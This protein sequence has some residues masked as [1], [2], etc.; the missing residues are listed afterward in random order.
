[1]KKIIFCW[2]AAV[3][4][5]MSLSMTGAWAQDAMTAAGDDEPVT[6][7]E[8]NFDE[9]TEVTAEELEVAEPGAFSW[10]SNA[11][12]NVR[13]A[14]T[15]DPIKKSG[16]ELKKAN[17][18]LLRARKVAQQN[19]DDPRLQDK[20]EK[21]N[22]KYENL[23]E[24]INLRIEKFKAD[25]PEA[26][27]LK[28]FL[29][30]YTDQQLKHQEILK[31]LEE[32]VP[33]Q[34]MEKIKVNREQHLERFGEV[35]NKLQTKEELKERLRKAVEVGAL[36]A[37]GVKARVEDRVERRANRAEILEELKEKVPEIKTQI[38]EIKQE[39]VELFQELKAKRE[40]IREKRQEFREGLKQE[41][42]E[43]KKS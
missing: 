18:E 9:A 24:R 3:I 31:N 38:Q 23:I 29:D 30:K 16:L 27:K 36:I 20:L 19:L 32:K 41:I 2:L 12:R 21:I 4:A 11:I 33:E 10:F 25:N 1:M 7:G 39:R 42:Q 17:F 26:P 5:L 35:M 8:V 22:E 14:I 43:I 15:R 37:E 40:E 34:V 13:I 6:T 28:N